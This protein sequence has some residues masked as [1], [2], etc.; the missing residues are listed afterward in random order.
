MIND[1]RW[2][3][4]FL[5]VVNSSSLKLAESEEAV[6]RLTSRRVLEMA[7]ETPKGERDDS[8]RV[9]STVQRPRL[10][11][12]DVA[13]FFV[14]NTGCIEASARNE[15]R[16]EREAKKQSSR[17]REFNET[18]LCYPLLDYSTS[19]SFPSR[20]LFLPS[21]RPSV[22]QFRSDRSLEIQINE[23]YI[24]LFRRLSSVKVPGG[25]SWRI[26]ARPYYSGMN[27]RVKNGFEF[28]WKRVKSK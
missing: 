1:S 27:N 16:S 12:D 6:V 21:F 22:L 14:R 9:V 13:S 7:L 10:P 25:K 19:Y 20:N 23:P 24:D 26:R 2:Q 15:I 18:F 17:Y 5:L 8:A 28:R 11:P 4:P 3:P